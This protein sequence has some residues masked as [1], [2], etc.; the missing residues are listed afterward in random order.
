[1]IQHFT[2]LLEC[3]DELIWKLKVF[4]ARHKEILCFK[5]FKLEHF[6]K[7]LPKKLSKVS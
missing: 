1:M 7:K 3:K 5:D 4:E 6:T 2:K